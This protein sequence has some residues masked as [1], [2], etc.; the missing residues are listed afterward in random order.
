LSRGMLEDSK[1]TKKDS[2][3]VFIRMPKNVQKQ[4]FQ[5]IDNKTKMSIF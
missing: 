2:T 1:T 5:K 3:N 4:I